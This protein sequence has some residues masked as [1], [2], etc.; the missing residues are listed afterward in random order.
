M[1]P[2]TATTLEELFEGSPATVH[3]DPTLVVSSLATDSRRVQPGALFFCLRGQHADG[4]AF[5]RQALAAGAAGIVADR[6]LALSDTTTVIV[7]D[8]LAALSKVST[9]FYGDPSSNL[10]VVGVT[11]TNG[12]TTT[13]YFIEA[14]A[15]AAG[16]RFGVIGTLGA[17]LGLEPVEDLLNTTPFAHDVQR[18]LAQFRDGG[19]RG[20]VLEVSSHALELHRVDDVRF[21]VT[22]LTNL[23][24]DHLD[25]HG[26]FEAYRAAK[27]R[28][29]SSAM[30]KHGNRPV[31]IV[32]LDDA[33]GRAL[34][35]IV[36][37]GRDARLLTYG[38]NNAEAL[39]DATEVSHSRGGSRFWVRSLRPAP[40]SIRLPG[41]FNVANAMAALAAACALDIDCEAIAEGLESL[42]AVPGRM[43]AVPAG[44]IGVYVDYAHTPDGLEQVLRTAR[45]LTFG[46]LVC[47]FGCGGDRDAAKRPRMGRIAQDLCDHV[48]VT[49]DNPRHE[50]P[51]AIVLD[52]LTGMD[53]SQDRHEVVMDRAAAIAR[54]IE[55]ARPGDSVVIAGKGHENYQIIGDERHP[56]SDAEV[57]GAAIAA[58]KTPT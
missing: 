50:E 2:A 46:R 31:A 18:L 34:A 14:I 10:T 27:R 30:G 29:F 57:A 45:A 33:E 24:H 41:A 13:T 44:E 17:R 37:T 54:A 35:S 32:S 4:H 53:E 47:V 43:V 7:P 20:A 49:T 36:R 6:D 12:K 9:H 51:Q 39:L 26:S 21:E 15:R 3:G 56:F 40:F 28:L 1:T 48:I 25:F 52:I 16:E 23:T 11:G 22:V 8:P 19:A 42:E 58:K 5:A 38:V 55:L